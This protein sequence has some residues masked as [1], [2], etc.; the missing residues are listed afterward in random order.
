MFSWFAP[1]MACFNCTISHQDTKIQIFF[2]CKLSQAF[3]NAKSY[4]DR[5][6]KMFLLASQCRYLSSGTKSHPCSAKFG[7]RYVGTVVTSLTH[8]LF[9]QCC[10]TLFQ[11]IVPP[12]ST[13]LHYHNNTIFTVW[14]LDYLC[15]HFIFICVYCRLTYGEPLCNP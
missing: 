11:K 15:I 12:H 10:T 13:T 4:F 7:L 9:S 1:G 14:R 5:N 2:I 8:R 6:T 3:C